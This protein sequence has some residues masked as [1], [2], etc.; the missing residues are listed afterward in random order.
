MKDIDK[1]IRYYFIETGQ[2]PP[3]TKA[4]FQI[5][6]NY[7]KEM[8]QATVKDKIQKTREYLDYFERHYD[9]VQKAWALINEKC[10]SKGFR[11]IYD[12]LVWQTIDNEVKA[13]DESKL[14]KNE[15]TQYRNFWFPAL[16]EKKND[17]DYLAAWEHH[18]KN[19]MHHWENW[20]AQAD[21]HY[22]DAFLV[23]NI[24]DWVAMGFEFGDT[25][26]D[27]YEKNADKIPFPDWAVKLMYDIFHCIYPEQ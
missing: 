18:K 23:M 17:A 4:E 20:I 25:A 8:Q 12:D 21:N 15:F 3:I 13:H 6:A 19:N 24:V 10:Q 14:S 16:N 9:N 22:A 7:L 11:F 26:K 2:I 27:Y 5:R 1:K